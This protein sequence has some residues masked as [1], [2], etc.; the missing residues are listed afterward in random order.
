MSDTGNPNEVCRQ[1]H[2]RPA[3]KQSSF[4]WN[5]PDKYVEL[6]NF[7]MEIANVLQTKMCKITE[8]EKVPVIKNWVV[9][10]GLQ[11]KQTFT[12]PRRK[13][14]AQQRDCFPH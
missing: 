7:E 10:E 3:L 9:R 2:G 4:N 11:L 6:L 14:T 1:R 12:I 13:H 8:E 5:A